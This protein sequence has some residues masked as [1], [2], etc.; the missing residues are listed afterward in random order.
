ML[1]VTA[2]LRMGQPARLGDWHAVVY[3]TWYGDDTGDPYLDTLNQPTNA[4]HAQAFLEERI[5]RWLALGAVQPVLSWLTKRYP[6]I[7]F[8]GYELFGALAARLLAVMC[9]TGWAVCSACSKIYDPGQRPNPNRRNY[10]PDCRAIGRPQRDAMRDF[11]KPDHVRRT[12]RRSKARSQ[13]RSQNGKK[14]S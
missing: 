3:G 10:C 14:G 4:T 13:T 6:T 1:N 8:D 12:K 9:G 5:N 7:V 2:A 11:R